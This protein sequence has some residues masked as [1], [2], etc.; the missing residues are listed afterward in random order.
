LGGNRREVT[1]QD[2]PLIEKCQNYARI[3]IPLILVFDPET[4]IA[5]Q[6]NGEKNRFEP[7][8]R[9]VLTNGQVIDVAEVWKELDRRLE[10]LNGHR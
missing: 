10:N 5:S 4:R 2:P 8:E 7:M 9:I 3:G 1:G 6:W